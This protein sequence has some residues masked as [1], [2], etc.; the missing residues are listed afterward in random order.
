VSDTN[1]ERKERRKRNMT[2]GSDVSGK[3][4]ERADIEID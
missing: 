1:A 2:N 3:F 4:S